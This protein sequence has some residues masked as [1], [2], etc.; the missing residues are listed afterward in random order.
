MASGVAFP[1]RPGARS[2]LS[3]PRVLVVSDGSGTPGVFLTSALDSEKKLRVVTGALFI[4]FM[5]LRVIFGGFSSYFSMKKTYID[6][7]Q[8]GY[9]S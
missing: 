7:F 1:E 3:W 5:D 4:G 2:D 9:D 6:T 8:W